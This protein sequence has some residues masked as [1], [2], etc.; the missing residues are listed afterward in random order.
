MSRR[1]KVT[2]DWLRKGRPL[3]DS[4][5]IR[6]IMLDAVQKEIKAKQEQLVGLTAD[7][8]YAASL[9]EWQ[10]KME[11][12]PTIFEREFNIPPLHEN[13]L[14]DKVI[15]D[16]LRWSLVHQEVSRRETPVIPS[17]E[18]LNT[19]SAAFMYG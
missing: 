13:P 17:G 2:L 7:D 8:D 4:T 15:D 3:D 11:L 12:S 5:I 6:H 19:I 14:P 18:T 10:E 1:A 9:I 16:A